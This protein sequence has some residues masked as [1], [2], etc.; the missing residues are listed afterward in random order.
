MTNIIQIIKGNSELEIVSSY[1]GIQIQFT[2]ENNVVTLYEGTKFYNCRMLLAHNSEIKIDRSQYEIHKLAI[3]SANFVNIT[4]GKDFSC[5]GVEIRCHEP[6]SRVVIG[7]DCM[8]SEE[9]L[10][11]PTDVHAIYDVYSNEVL[12]YSKPITIGDHVWCGRRVTILKGVVLRDNVVIGMN[13]VLTKKI[14]ESNIV[15]GGNPATVLKR[16]VNWDRA[17]PYTRLNLNQ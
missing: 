4:I 9:I 15:V 12:N 2:G 11:Y 8:F 10:I 5:W 14:N 6:K 13:T 17:S 1:P 3:W 16:G 7:R